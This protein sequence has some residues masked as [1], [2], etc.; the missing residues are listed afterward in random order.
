[1]KL[2]AKT[3][4]WRKLL[5]SVL[6]VQSCSRN[7]KRMVI[8]LIKFLESMEIPYFIDSAGNILAIKGEAETYPCVVSHMDTVHKFV[9]DYRLL[10]YKDENNTLFAKDGDTKTGIGGDDKCGV[11]ACMYFLTVLPAVKVVFFTQ[12]ESGCVGSRGIN[13]DYFADCRYL[14]QLD[15]KGNHDL[16]QKY[17]GDKTISKAFRSNM[18]P[19][20]E[21]YGFK[22]ASGSV[23]DVMRLFDRGVGLCCLNI[24][25]GYYKPHSD[26]EYINTDDLA[27]SINFTQKLILALGTMQ[28]RYVKLKK[29]FVYTTTTTNTTSVTYPSKRPCQACGTMTQ[30]ISLFVMNG[31]KICWECY[32]TLQ[33]Y[34]PKERAE[35]VTKKINRKNNHVT[36]YKCI[37]CNKLWKT[38]FCWECNTGNLPID[39]KDTELI[40]T[41]VPTTL[42][43]GD[44]TCK[45]CGKKLEKGVTLRCIDCEW[46]CIPCANEVTLLKG[47][48]RNEPFILT[49]EVCHTVVLDALS[50]KWKFGLIMC[51]E[52]N[53]KAKKETQDIL[54]FKILKNPRI[55]RKKTSSKIIH[56]AIQTVLNNLYYCNECKAV[57]HEKETFYA[58]NNDTDIKHVACHSDLVTP[59]VE[60]N[61]V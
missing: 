52:C 50:A 60:K 7:E 3:S 21:Q 1:M 41:N 44:Y 30:D 53:D 12:E 15:R 51:A 25:S 10:H 16:I 13:L 58:S 47:T 56:T 54:N 35:I 26:N 32:R 31:Q 22:P 39:K 43:I 59:Y 9:K 42:T 18:K 33:K 55:N 8:F 24:S 20:R 49:C 46:Y 48:S 61:C 2:S 14:L 36:N 28:Y 17:W 45:G 40:D 4:K 38:S 19:I 29:K 11:F 57:I 34:L 6:E 27:N 37:E 5:I 23:T